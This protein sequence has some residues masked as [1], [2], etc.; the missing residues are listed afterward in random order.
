MLA[1]PGTGKTTTI[2]EAVAARIDAGAD[3]EQILVLT[4]SRKAAAELRSRITARVGRTIRE[5]LARTFHSYAYGVL[6]RAAAAARR[7][8]APAADLGRAGRR[9]RRAA[10][11]RRRGGGRRPLARGLAPALETAGFRTEL[12]ELLLRATE[13]GV[14]AGA[15]GR[16]GPRDRP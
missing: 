2:V 1:G 6:R 5:P 10:P 16:L 8:A 12:R 9:R 4:F 14:D 3:P 11:R 15:A 13:R 7:A